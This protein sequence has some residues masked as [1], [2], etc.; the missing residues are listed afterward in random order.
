MNLKGA[1][2]IHWY[3]NDVD[4]IVIT[5][6]ITGVDGRPIILIADDGTVINWVHVCTMERPKNAT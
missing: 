6:V 4:Y 2:L 1:W 5:E 3:N